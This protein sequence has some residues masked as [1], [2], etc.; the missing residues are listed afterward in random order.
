[1]KKIIAIAFLAALVACGEKEKA[2]PVAATPAPAAIVDAS[3]Y[4]E[5]TAAVKLRAEPS[6]TAALAKCRSIDVSDCH[7]SA[8]MGESS[9]IPKERSV[10]VV[11]RTDV[12]EK[13]SGAE[14]YWYQVG[15]ADNQCKAW[16]FGGFLKPAPEI[17]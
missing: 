4:M 2:A 10:S 1:M 16:I 11:K 12:K 9:V 15:G 13:I 6:A 5:T 14:G 8:C 7:D 17:K 3:G